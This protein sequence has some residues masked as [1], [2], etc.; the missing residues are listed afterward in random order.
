LGRRSKARTCRCGR[1]LRRCICLLSPARGFP[2]SRWGVSRPLSK[3]SAVS[4]PPPPRHDGRQFRPAWRG[5]VEADETSVGGKR[6]RGQKSRLTM[7]AISP[8]GAAAATRSSPPSS[9][10]G[11]PR[12]KRA[13]THSEWTI[14]TFLFGKVS[15]ESV[16]SVDELPAYRW[17]GRKFD[18]HLCVNHSAGE[19]V[20]T[21]PHAAAKAHP[22]SAESWNP[23]LKRAPCRQMDSAGEL[24]ANAAANR[25]RRQ[26]IALA[27]ACAVGSPQRRPAHRTGLGTHGWAA[28]GGARLWA[29]HCMS[30]LVSSD[31]PA[32]LARGCLSRPA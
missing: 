3:D 5:I 15:L 4:W 25:G 12:A 20:R 6:K 13:S 30:P 10:A 28:T 2:A 24:S 19:Y 29:E 8:K 1:G 27:V 23:T 26:L 18:A 22:N 32:R 17:I 31:D 9:G 16:L 7:T 11:S 21:E 14:V